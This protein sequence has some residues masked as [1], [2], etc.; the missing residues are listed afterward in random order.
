MIVILPI[1]WEPVDFPKLRGKP[2]KL[3][4]DIV[5]Y[6]YLIMIHPLP[7]VNNAT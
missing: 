6:K 5:D 2:K 7:S 3:H 4:A 1:S